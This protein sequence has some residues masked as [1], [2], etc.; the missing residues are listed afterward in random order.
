MP[1]RKRGREEIDNVDWLAAKRHAVEAIATIVASQKRKLEDD[2]TDTDSPAKRH[3]TKPHAIEF[4]ATVVASQKRKLDDNKSDTNHLSK[5]RAIEVIA[6]AVASQKRRLEEEGTNTDHLAKRRA[7]EAIATVIA[8]QKRKLEDGETD[9][10]HIA[11][12]RALE[13]IAIAVAFQK[14]KLEDDETDT[15]PPAKRKASDGDAGITVKNH[16]R[17]LEEEDDTNQRPT[18]RQPQ[19][20]PFKSIAKDRMELKNAFRDCT[21]HQY[22]QVLS[23]FGKDTHSIAIALMDSPEGLRLRAIQALKDNYRNEVVDAIS[24]IQINKNRFDPYNL[25]PSIITHQILSRLLVESA[26]CLIC[27]DG[28]VDC[29]DV[30]WKHCKQHLM[31]TACFRRVVAQGQMPLFGYC[32]CIKDS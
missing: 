23:M 16:K 17:P 19:A 9:S 20:N 28:F 10:D 22:L 18:K 26:V 21:W 1:S 6:T 3:A 15:N 31:H 11:K 4:V 5:R 25:F 32:D 30:I 27:Q 12:R 29:T 7:I 24:D 2:E 14:R 8:S 13:A